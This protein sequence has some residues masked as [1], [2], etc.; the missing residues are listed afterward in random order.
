MALDPR[1]RSAIIDATAAAGQ[2]HGLAT[3]LIAWFDALN[4]GNE[5]LT[6]KE[7]VS[8]HMEL[9]YGLARERDPYDGDDEDSE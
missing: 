4:S 6:D 9:F 5:T 1:V 3:K 8:R 2:D 7:S